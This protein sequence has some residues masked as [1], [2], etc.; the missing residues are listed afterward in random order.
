MQHMRETHEPVAANEKHQIHML[1]VKAPT[2]DKSC[3]FH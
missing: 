3:V 2:L 1:N